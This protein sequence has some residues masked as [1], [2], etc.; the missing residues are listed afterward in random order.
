MG[1]KP[2][3]TLKQ[4]EARKQPTPADAVKVVP[5]KK[6]G[7]APVAE[8]V[9]KVEDKAYRCG[10]RGQLLVKNLKAAGVKVDALDY[11]GVTHEFFGMG[12]VAKAK[13]AE[14]AVGKDLEAA[15]AAAKKTASE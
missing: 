4:V 2:I 14:Q 6:L 12:A 3:E 7:K 5:T 8:A 9:A 10:T 1:G 13:K 11:T 15:F